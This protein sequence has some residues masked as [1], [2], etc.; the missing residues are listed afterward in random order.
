M[1]WVRVDPGIVVHCMQ[2][3]GDVCLHSY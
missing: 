3:R 2:A 1:E